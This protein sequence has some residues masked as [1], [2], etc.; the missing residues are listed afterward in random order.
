MTGRRFGGTYSKGGPTEPGKPPGNKF[1]GRRVQRGSGGAKLIYAAALPMGLAGLL[2][3]GSG[4]AVAMIAELGSFALMFFSAWMTSEGVKAANAFEARTV[5]R[6]PSIP[7]KII[8]GVALG[9]GVALGGA[10]GWQLGIIQGVLFGIVA[11]G[12]HLVA[13]GPD[14]MKA[15]GLDDAS[16]FDRDRVANAIDKAET[17]V[18]Q[19]MDQARGIGDRELEGR[20][21]RLATAA[22]AVFRAVEEDPRDL[23]RARKFMGV[24]L[25][26][27]R[28]ATAKFADIYSR[29]RDPQA[30]T[31]FVALLDDLESSFNAHRESLLIE[32]RTDL[33]IEIEVL[34]DR[35]KYEGVR[36]R[37]EE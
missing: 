18:G 15:K 3:I 30:R 26:G 11:A 4:D 6:P 16:D 21:E 24:Y 8:G 17:L 22:R 1:D 35:L 28:D 10:F 33:D 7:R 20:V 19:L 5:A 34:R 9:L 32:D 14:P 25:T 12:A 29:S 36:P 37:M 27:A 31:D 13:F 23:P 2:E